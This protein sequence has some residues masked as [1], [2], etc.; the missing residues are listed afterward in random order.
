MKTLLLTIVLLALVAGT[1]IAQDEECIVRQGQSCWFEV[2]CDFTVV[3][4]VIN[5]DGGFNLSSNE[6]EGNFIAVPV[7]DG[8]VF[9]G[10]YVECDIVTPTDPSTWGEIKAQYR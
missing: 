2:G 4:L 7:E 6:P 3:Y 8:K 9:L 10:D 1:A 5:E